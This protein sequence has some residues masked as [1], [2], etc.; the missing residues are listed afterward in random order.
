MGGGAES[1]AQTHT[2]ICVHVR[3]GQRVLRCEHLARSG[4]NEELIPICI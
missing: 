1:R 4:R 3:E 2:G